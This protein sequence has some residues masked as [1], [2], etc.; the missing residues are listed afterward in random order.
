[1]RR[2]H[3]LTASALLSLLGAPAHAQSEFDFTYSGTLTEVFNCPDAPGGVCPGADPPGS[4]RLV[5]PWNGTASFITSSS[6]NV[7][8][9]CPRPELGCHG[10]GLLQIVLDGEPW[11]TWGPIGTG[12]GVPATPLSLTLVGGAI[13]SMSGFFSKSFPHDFYYTDGSTLAYSFISPTAG[14]GPQSGSGVA[15]LT[16]LPEPGSWALVLAG[17]ALLGAGRSIKAART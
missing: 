11:L 17:L 8:Y 5:F 14:P 2:L 13:A 16:L 1:M 10:D 15:T 3:V 12:P 7:V 6:A 4:N 9:S